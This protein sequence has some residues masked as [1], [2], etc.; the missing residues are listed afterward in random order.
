[1]VSQES[2]LTFMAHTFWCSHTHLVCSLIP[3]L[4]SRQDSSCQTEEAEMC[5]WQ[6]LFSLVQPCK[7]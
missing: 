2:M 4:G 3:C 7:A 5:S 1:M 6:K